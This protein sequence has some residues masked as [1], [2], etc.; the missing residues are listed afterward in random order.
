MEFGM[1]NKHFGEVLRK[2]REERGVSLRKFAEKVGITP[3]YLSKIERLEIT[4]APSEEVIRKAAIELG[5]DFDELMILAGRV[6]S[7]LPEIISQ[8][9]REMAALLRTARNMSKEELERFTKSL[10]H[11]LDT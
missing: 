3:T 6:P 7:E 4:K 1:E 11:K 2:L 10:Q 5:A 8:R 9:P